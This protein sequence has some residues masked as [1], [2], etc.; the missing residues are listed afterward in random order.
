MSRQAWKLTNIL[1]IILIRALLPIS[2]EQLI[3]A[4]PS[5]VDRL[6]HTDGRH[7]K[8]QRYTFLARRPSRVDL[9]VRR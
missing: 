4:I 3:D 8:K 9:A 1:W 6:D 5:I 7:R 2:I